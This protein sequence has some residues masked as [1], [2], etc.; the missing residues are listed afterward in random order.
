MLKIDKEAEKL[1][2]TYVRSLASSAPHNW[3]GFYDKK[4][5]LFKWPLLNPVQNYEHK[6]EILAG[7][8][9]HFKRDTDVDKD[10]AIS[11][12][13]NLYSS[14]IAYDLERIWYKDVD[15]NPSFHFG[16]IINGLYSYIDEKLIVDGSKKAKKA[17]KAAKKEKKAKKDKKKD[18]NEELENDGEVPGIAENPNE[19][20]PTDEIP[21]LM[22]EEARNIMVNNIK[23]IFQERNY[24]LEILK[25]N[26]IM[27]HPVKY[28]MTLWATKNLLPGLNTREYKEILLK[29]IG[30]LDVQADTL[31]TLVSCNRQLDLI[32]VICFSMTSFNDKNLIQC[33]KNV[34][35]EKD[36][37]KKPIINLIKEHPTHKG[38]WAIR[39][40][41]YNESKKF[42]LNPSKLTPEVTIIVLAK[43]A[44]KRIRSPTILID[45]A[46]PALPISSAKRQL[47]T[48]EIY[49]SLIGVFVSLAQQTTIFSFSDYVKNWSKFRK[50]FKDTKIYN[51]PSTGEESRQ[52]FIAERLKNAERSKIAL[53]EDQKQAIG[54]SSR[55]YSQRRH[56]LIYGLRGTGKTSCLRIRLC[57]RLRLDPTEAVIY[58][59]LRPEEDDEK[60]TESMELHPRFYHFKLDPEK[61]AKDFVDPP[62]KDIKDLISRNNLSNKHKIETGINYIESNDLD[63]E[64]L[65]SYSYFI[66]N[67]D[68]QK[69]DYVFFNKIFLKIL[70]FEETNHV[71]VTSRVD[72][73]IEIDKSFNSHLG[74]VNF[75]CWELNT[76]VRG[77]IQINQLYNELALDL[78]LVGKQ[79]KS[80]ILS[81]RNID[82]HTM[83]AQD[84]EF[85]PY[86]T[87]RTAGTNKSISKIANPLLNLILDPT[88]SFG[89]TATNKD[90]LVAFIAPQGIG[91]EKYLSELDSISENCRL[92]NVP[93]LDLS[94][95]NKV[96]NNAEFIKNPTNEGKL[97]SEY[98]IVIACIYADNLEDLREGNKPVIGKIWALQ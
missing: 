1:I 66:D 57:E 49:K 2:T 21:C 5:T 78:N 35:L 18:K 51:I 72:K 58:I 62:I 48:P 13:L 52:D 53:S 30:E 43:E 82:T 64:N 93:F 90:I 29:S 23:A 81:Y 70:D 88:R 85:I 60:M 19:T 87:G 16:A 55:G 27:L 4:S 86:E 34:K 44:I 96:I 38:V 7:T 3:K 67:F 69:D 33:M 61:E 50:G 79:S 63:F 92:E 32:R 6:E 8:R 25:R 14:D 94:N 98:P 36:D 80:A 17:K 91:Q 28:T 42:N 37:D 65:E 83:L 71:M 11:N 77:N 74:H 26:V 89:A 73:K 47:I 46:K 68:E 9:E 84:I 54:L 12:K 97:K 45:Y 15:Q 76:R 95:Q 20:E 56:T 59:N 41:K 39:V 75:K 10:K 22:T 24:D 31:T 40:N